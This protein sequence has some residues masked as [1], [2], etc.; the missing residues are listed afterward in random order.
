MYNYLLI[1][2]D[3][4]WLKGKNR[5]QYICHLNNHLNY[6]LK[7]QNYDFKY[8]NINQRLVFKFEKK[9]NDNLINIIS[10]IPGISL[11]SPACK[12]TSSIDEVV[13]LAIKHINSLKKKPKTFKVNT[14]RSD[15]NL[16]LTSVKLNCLVGDR[17]ISAFNKKIKVDL[18]NPHICIDIYAYLDYFF[19]S[20][21]KF[22]GIGG[23]PI[24]SSKKALTLLSGGIDSPVASYLMA[25]RGLMQTFVFFYAYP[26]VSEEVKDKILELANTLGIF[27]KKS[28]LIIIPF[29]KLQEYIA[30]RCRESYRT[31]FFRIAMIKV[32]NHLAKKFD[33]KAII[34]GDSLGQVSSQSLDNISLIDKFSSTLVLRPLIGMNKSEITKIAE[35][36][37]TYKT[38]ILPHDDACSLFSSKHPIISPNFNYCKKF[39]EDNSYFNLIEQSIDDCEVYDINPLKTFKKESKF[40]EYFNDVFNYI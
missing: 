19:V 13:S 12:I 8:E 36:I 38:S 1:S 28:S 30:Q 39:M 24:G 18:K 15:N 37:N 11:I 4:T 5:H 23:L 25:K 16:K 33:Y 22:H 32:C 20:F 27:L 7:S 21:K 31:M 14:K 9:I 2:M 35:Q 10:K 6:I 40:Q 29:G 26:F 34:T 17:F 3:E